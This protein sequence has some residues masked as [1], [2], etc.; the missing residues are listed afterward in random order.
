MRLNSRDEPAKEELL[1]NAARFF[2]CACCGKYFVY[3]K[4]EELHLDSKK[5][6]LDEACEKLLY[7]N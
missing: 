1:L 3:A 6:D 7:V 5:V 4:T 2:M